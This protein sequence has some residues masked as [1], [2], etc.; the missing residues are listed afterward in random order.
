MKLSEKGFELIKGFE[1][2]RLKAYQDGGGVWTIGYGATLGVHEG[3][4][5]TQEQADE[6]LRRDVRGAEKCLNSSVAVPLTEG[7]ADACISLIF[8]IGCH[9]WRTSTLLRLLNDSDYDGAAAQFKR[10]NKDNGQV[11]AGLVNRRAAEAERF[12]ESA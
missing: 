12:E 8:N 1:G 4:E 11:V 3:M 6:L 2:C 7:E 5:I 10:W 9:A